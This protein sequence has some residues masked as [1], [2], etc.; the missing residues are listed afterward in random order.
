MKQVSD[1]RENRREAQSLFLHWVCS[2]TRQSSNGK[3]AVRESNRR[4]YNG[5]TVQTTAVGLFASTSVP[6]ELNPARS[7]MLSHSLRLAVLVVL[8]VMT[9]HLCLASKA[10][11]GKGG[12]SVTII[13]G[14]EWR[15]SHPIEDESQTWPHHDLARR[16]R[17]YIAFDAET[18]KGSPGCGTLAGTFHGSGSRISIAAKWL[19]DPGEPC[20]AG[21]R[22]DAS[23]IVSALNRVVQINAKPKYWQDDA[24]LLSDGEG[25]TRIVLSPQ[26][27]G[28][29]LSE[30]TDTF[31]HLSTLSG[32]AVE[33]SDAVVWI[34]D[35]DINFS[36]S[37]G[38]FSYPFEYELA[39]LKFFPVWHSETGDSTLR[40]AGD[41]RTAADFEVALHR[42][43]T[44]RINGDHLIFS[45]NNR[46]PIMILNR[47]PKTGIE[48]H[49][50]RIA[51]Y[52]STKGSI[53]NRSS[54]ADAKEFSDI[55]FLQ[56]RIHGSPGCGAWLG[57]YRLDHDALVVKAHSVV[58]APCSN[59]EEAQNDEVVNIFK[60]DLRVEYLKDEVLLST[61]D[62]KAAIVLLEF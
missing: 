52:R 51:K 27:T 37:S 41:Q 42:I 17:P 23:Q 26:R 21:D 56:G 58:A 3:E 2:S 4:R 36:T 34:E 50:W 15:I 43:T 61:V 10:P 54:V 47:I 9:N 18:I 1:A 13:E 6:L 55:T 33:S 40:L 19:D 45:A 7:I 24:F 38:F 5:V 59:A 60:S 25:K 31:W 20:D 44:Y 29:D 35:R 48:A 28:S 11:S 30:L 49:R 8:G 57:S 14:R 32:A 22:D 46:L 39:G 53:A 12:P 16:T 62:G